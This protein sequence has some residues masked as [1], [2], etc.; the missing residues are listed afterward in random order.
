MNLHKPMNHITMATLNGRPCRIVSDDE[1]LELL[2]SNNPFKAINEFHP[3]CTVTSNPG[4]S[5]NVRIFFHHSTID[6]VQPDFT[7]GD[8]F[9]LRYLRH[10]TV[11]E[12]EDIPEHFQ[13]DILN[14]SIR[15][16]TANIESTNYA[17]H[18]NE[19][20]Q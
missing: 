10:L 12:W 5:G 20:Q 8:E 11:D 19:Q 9:S 15:K 18:V 6:G 17:V 2:V 4:Y 3:V 7:T 13:H 1:N 16:L 14:V